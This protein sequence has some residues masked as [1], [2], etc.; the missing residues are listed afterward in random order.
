MLTYWT[1]KEKNE[2]KDDKED[3]RRTFDEAIHSLSSPTPAPPLSELQIPPPS[4][5]A[6]PPESQVPVVS[7]G[8]STKEME[9]LI[10]QLKSLLSGIPA[11]GINPNV[12]GEPP[13]SI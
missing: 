10:E 3:S 12:S 1:D 2:R 13:C 11:A 8:A 9:K 6:A 7:D 4:E 5:P